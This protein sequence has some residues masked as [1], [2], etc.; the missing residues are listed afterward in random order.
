MSAAEFASVPERF[1]ITAP[2][3]MTPEVSVYSI[4]TEIYDVSITGA[5]TGTLFLQ[6]N[7]GDGDWNTIS[8][9]TEPSEDT[10]NFS[11]GQMNLRMMA[12]DDFSGTAKILFL[13]GTRNVN[14][15][16]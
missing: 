10:G 11:A 13:Q 5:F 4:V 8:S 9:Y 2:G 6:C 7:Y 1:E 15:S 14:E 16:L 12:G 3:Q